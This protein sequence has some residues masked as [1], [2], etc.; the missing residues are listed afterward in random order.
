MVRVKLV[1]LLWNT[2]WRRVI[3]LYIMALHGSIKVYDLENN[4]HWNDYKERID[5][6]FLANDIDIAAKQKEIFLTVIGSRTYSLVKNLARPALPEDK[7]YNQLAD[8]L[9]THL[10][11]TPIVHYTS[12]SFQDKF[13][14]F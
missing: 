8:I 14:S 1:S 2:T 6:Y 10:C 11:P 13:I 5:Q 3:N 12:K 4:E 9:R 7:S